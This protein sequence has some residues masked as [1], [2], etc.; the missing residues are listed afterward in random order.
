MKYISCDFFLLSYSEKKIN[1]VKY[2][3]QKS[4]IDNVIEPWNSSN[5][6]G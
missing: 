6:W 3:E 1:T 4:E 2:A 5:L